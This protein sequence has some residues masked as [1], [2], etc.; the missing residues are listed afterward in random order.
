MLMRCR[1]PA[2]THLPLGGTAISGHYRV[3]RAHRNPPKVL[4]ARQ[5]RHDAEMSGTIFPDFSTKK[6]GTA[7]V[8]DKYPLIGYMHLAR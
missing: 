6:Q 1:P 7:F 4:C 2:E 8:M 3:C 5:A